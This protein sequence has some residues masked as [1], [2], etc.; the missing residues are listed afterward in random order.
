MRIIKTL[1]RLGLFSLFVLPATS[2]EAV[3]G[4]PECFSLADLKKSAKGIGKSL[5]NPVA[6]SS[7][8]TKVKK[9]AKSTYQD[10]LYE[11]VEMNHEGVFISVS[12]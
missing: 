2:L 6:Q 11:N 3:P 12:F 8:K 4:T 9:K 10:F 5:L 7:D 1:G